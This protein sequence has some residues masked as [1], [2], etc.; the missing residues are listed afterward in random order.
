MGESTGPTQGSQ[1]L[2]AAPPP[3]DDPVAALESR[4]ALPLPDR[5]V[6]LAAVT[7]K[8][9]A[10]EHRGEAIADNERLEFLGDAVIDLAVSHRLMERFPAAREGEL[11][12]MRAAVVDEQGLS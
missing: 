5:E 12:K 6:A 11:S 9:Y 4:L 1:P 2:L 8:S 7:H 10:N 3:P